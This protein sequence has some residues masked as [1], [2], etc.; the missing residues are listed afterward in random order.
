MVHFLFST[1]A[2]GH[3]GAVIPPPQTKPEKKKTLTF[4]PKSLK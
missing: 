1:L 3:G 4:Y 2:G